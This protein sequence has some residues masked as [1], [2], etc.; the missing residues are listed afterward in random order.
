VPESKE[1]KGLSLFKALLS[2]RDWVYLLSLLI[3]FIFYD[4]AL[5]AS[6]IASQP[7]YHGLVLSLE[8]MGSDILFDL[9]YALL[10]IG[11]FVVARKGFA[12]WVVVFFF[13]LA[14]VLV[15]LVS[16]CAHQY[17]RE[18]GTT[19][20]YPTIVEWLPKLNQI[21]PILVNDIPLS[22]WA[23]L[24]GALFYATVGPWLITHA[25]KRWRG[26]PRR[27]VLQTPQP[28]F[29]GPLALFL[30]ALGFGSL[31]PLIGI[32]P[33]GAD[34]SLARNPFVNVVLTGLEEATYTDDSTS[35]GGSVAKHPSADATLL[36]TS[37]TDKRNVVIIH[38]ES[39]R[40]QSVTP[41]NQ[42][43]PTTP[44]LD[45]L[46]KKSLLA[47]RAYTI[48]PRTSKANVA[49][50]CGIEPP[51]YPGPEF[52]PGGI[53]SPCLANLLKEQGYNTVYFMSTSETMDNFGDVVTNFGYDKFY[54]AETMDTTG[55]Q[56]T[57]TFGY[58]DDIMLKPSQ[59]WL[60]DH[61]DKP[62]LA[63]Y[64]T[65]TG[66]YGYEC[67][68][69]RYG[70]QN[71]SDDDQLNHYLNCLN[72]LDHFVKNLIDQYKELGLYDNTIF[73][74]YGDHG[75]GF[76][77]HGLYM[78]GDTPYEEGVKIPLIIHAPGWF[79]NGERVKGLANETDIVP[80]V[81]EMLGYKLQGG[82]YPGYSLLHTLPADR[83]LR[84]SCISERKCLASLNGNE[85]YI[86]HYDNQP[87]EV[88]DLSKDPLEK[89]NLADQ[90]KEDLDKRRRDLL[91]WH[92]KVD[93]M[94]SSSESTS[95]GEGA[96]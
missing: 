88:F 90:Y 2:R 95:Q 28:S 89:H 62:F 18:M 35:S 59:E 49:V 37:N 33:A 42:D 43:L 57:N 71:F 17:F 53:P 76:G 30:L 47:E 91:A 31:S 24:F 11:L 56:V 34:A 93:A 44:F 46:A 36:Q 27:A 15:V 84:F 10:W 8:M 23:L 52:E 83:T 19:L 72:Y 73:V 78:H 86:Y 26:W 3:P 77:E 12:R 4:L 80:T 94:Y 61:K 96:S 9:G 16:T 39:T 32:T 79:V 40:A 54:S 92:S 65:G 60:E 41:Y 20:D 69:N 85:K 48:V 14:T 51:L 67:I 29:V 21:E 75:E 68:P 82:E 64:L 50:N 45:E 74:L 87:E 1:L 55:F 66:H 13:H 81:L 6:D 58:E 22:A 5:K 63:E 7:A 70:T 25:L 38:L